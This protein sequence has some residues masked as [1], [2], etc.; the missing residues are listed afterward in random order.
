MVPT[1]SVQRLFTAHMP[2][3]V[4]SLNQAL[5]KAS[6]RDSWLAANSATSA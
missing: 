4:V 3:L 1:C 5:A 6:S 2:P